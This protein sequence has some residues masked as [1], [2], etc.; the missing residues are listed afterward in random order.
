MKKAV[1]MFI[2]CILPS[3]SFAEYRVV[4][5]DEGQQAILDD[6]RRLTVFQDAPIEI[7][8]P[9]CVFMDSSKLKTKG[10]DN[11]EWYHLKK[12]SDDVVIVE[13]YKYS[14]KLPSYIAENEK[15]IEQAVPIKGPAKKSGILKVHGIKIRLTVGSPARISAEIL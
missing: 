3:V 10:L 4:T 2:L 15:T 7:D 8:D 9:I 12:I 1:L 5:A 6:D 13:V 11:V 14:L